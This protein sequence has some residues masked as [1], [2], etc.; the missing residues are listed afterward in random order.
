MKKIIITGGH[1]TPA[2]A[3][4]DELKKRGCWQIYFLGRK[5][6]MEGEKIP[7]VEAKI[8]P[9]L[10]GVCFLPIITGRLQRRFTSQTLF[11]LLKVPIG[12]F[13][14]FVFLVKIK[15][16]VVVS[17]GGYVSVPVVLSSWLLRIPIIT[18][19]QTTV[20]G[21]A[22]K[23]NSLFAKK[24]AVSFRES[25]RYFPNQKVVL[26][27]NPLRK[28]IFE[29]GKAP[30]PELK[31]LVEKEK[32]PLIYVTGGSQG[33]QVINKALAEILKRALGK[34]IILHQTGEKDLEKF[35]SIRQDLPKNLKKRYF[36]ASFVNSSEIGW[37][38]KNA[39]IVISRAGAN[40]IYELAA[41]GK[42]AILI[43]I[44]FA[45]KNE[46]MKNA[47][48]LKKEGL[49]KILPQERL[50]GLTLMRMINTMFR[51]L[52]NYQKA[53]SK[54]KSLV[55]KDAAK[56]LVDQIEEIAKA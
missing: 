18:H 21:L 28:E 46:Q 11:S 10:P 17:F 36:V 25:S 5:Y 31:E 3:V 14:S 47:L 49:V 33:A 15:P 24:I 12:I 44:P 56:K 26:T 43:P 34:Y 55:E 51:K 35:L 50:S 1:L 13:Q 27:G 45:Y 48:L 41:L 4:I 37:V 22:S 40:T 19:E 54:A 32:H 9:S 6:S 29:A 42:P 7:S 38:F 39:K 53:S 23:I 30:F 8:V 52:N 20:F 16:N 2:L